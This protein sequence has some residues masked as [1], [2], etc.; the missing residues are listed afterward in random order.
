MKQGTVSP[1]DHLK[2][3]V[4]VAFVRVHQMLFCGTNWLI[5]RRLIYE[6]SKTYIMLIYNAKIQCTQ[7]VSP[8]L[9]KVLLSSPGR[10][11][12]IFDVR[13]FGWPFSLL[14]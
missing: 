11:S 14:T 12:Y 4:S 1:Q 7:V 10:G 6:V 9:F 8:Y 5:S 13:G 2:L 3:E